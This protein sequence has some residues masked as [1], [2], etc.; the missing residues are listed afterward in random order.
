MS[1]EDNERIKHEKYMWI[2][3]DAQELELLIKKE[4]PE[5]K[6]KTLALTKL[7]EVA[8]LAC[9]AIEQNN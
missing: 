8:Q 5:S 2:W 4:C 6:E 1:K 7:E 3:D 9:R